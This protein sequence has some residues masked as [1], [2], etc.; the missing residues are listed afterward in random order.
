MDQKVRKL[1]NHPL[2]G[3][4]PPAEIR[5]LAGRV[6]IERLEPGEVLFQQGDKASASYVI[7][8]GE[9]DAKT[10]DTRTGRPQR[11]GRYFTD[12]ITGDR[13]VI[14][15]SPYR[16]SVQAVQP[17]EVIRI[18]DHVF[19][20]LVGRYPHIRE[21]VLLDTAEEEP[22]GGLFFSYPD[23]RPDE[24]IIKQM[25]KHWIVPIQTLTG[26]VLLMLI[27]T[28]ILGAI[29]LV[30][31]DSFSNS[32]AVYWLLAV[33]GLIIIGL[34]GWFLWE[35]IDWLNDYYIVTTHRVI[36]I[37]KVAFFFEEHRES[38]IEKIQDVSLR[39]DNPIEQIL[40]YGDLTISTASQADQIMFRYVP[41]PSDLQ[42]IILNL[43]E[44]FQ[45]RV[46]QR[47]QHE[48]RRALERALGYDDDEEIEERT[49]GEDEAEA[50]SPAPRSRPLFET[51]IDYIN[52]TNLREERANGA[53]LW[54]KHWIV[55][56]GEVFSP[57]LF[58]ML[59]LA[60]FVVGLVALQNEMFSWV[61]FVLF[62][63]VT[64]IVAIVW[65]YWQYEDWRNDVYI[66]TQ[67][68]VVD[69]QRLPLGFE[70]QI[71]RAP[72]G[73]IQDIQYE[74]PN[75][76]YTILNVGNVLIQTASVEGQLTF[77]NVAKPR[78]V[79]REIY[80]R[81]RVRE[82]AAQARR[83]R[84]RDEAIAEMLALYDNIQEQRA[85]GL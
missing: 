81:L 79:T 72:L 11:R 67:D 39:I 78:D 85:T 60:G 59:W 15:G 10:V 33:W 63:G 2:L 47:E 83:E 54:R 9:L 3:S 14:D 34:I 50:H 38:P 70:A 55:L 62:A 41:D 73:T 12:D 4:L 16:A 76:V 82:E 29:I 71:R 58:L 75:P 21:T 46:K 25:R 31:P 22:E 53:I 23:L 68:A 69:E 48:K 36:H 49:E 30:A 51:F 8:S 57:L 5:S 35:L 40:D 37:E 45:S 26:P 6:E 74:I 61:P 84:Q 56:I 65:L 24:R 52:P 1:R 7:V 43:K 77:N 17:T 18:P 42:H 64:L 32:Q 27:A 13:E 66:L 44:K 80:E 28:G 19:R 20:R